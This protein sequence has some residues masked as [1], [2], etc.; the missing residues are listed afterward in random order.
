MGRYRSAFKGAA[1][2]WIKANVAPLVAT[3]LDRAFKAVVDEHRAIG[4]QEAANAKTAGVP[5]KPSHTL[6]AIEQLMSRIPEQLA[7]LREG[8]AAPSP[9]GVLRGIVDL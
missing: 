4:S 3:L 8:G 5:F 6:L 1:R 7:S 9:R 2:T